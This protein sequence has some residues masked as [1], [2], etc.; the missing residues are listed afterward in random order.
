L[1]DWQF[2]F[3]LNTLTISTH[4]LLVFLFSWEDILSGLL[5]KGW[6]TFPLLLSR[7]PLVFDFQHFANDVFLGLFTIVLL[8]LGNN[9]LPLF[10]EALFF[11]HSFLSPFFGLYN[12]YKFILMQAAF[13]RPVPIFWWALL[14]SFS[15]LLLYLQL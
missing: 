11:L 6:V 3:S 12:L 5:F 4:C 1:I 13:L 7:F 10:S 9:S 8:L 14:V 15:F 2:F